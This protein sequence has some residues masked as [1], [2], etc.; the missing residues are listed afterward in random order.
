MFVK[1]APGATGVYPPPVLIVLEPTSAYVCGLGFENMTTGSEAGDAGWVVE[2]G[3]TGTADELVVPPPLSLP[4][5]A[6]RSH[7][8]LKTASRQKRPCRFM[9][10]PDHN[11][12]DV[13]C[14]HTSLS[15]VPS[16]R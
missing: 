3:G 1:R 9:V 11:G 8:G 12:V 5:H 6:V 7:T 13:A 10:L 15:L 16:A 14:P 4:P 2:I